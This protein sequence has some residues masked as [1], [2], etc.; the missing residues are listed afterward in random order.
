M[1]IYRIK[2]LYG[3]QLCILFLLWLLLHHRSFFK[4][5]F[6]L[7]FNIIFFNKLQDI[8]C[9]VPKCLLGVNFYGV[10]TSYS[11]YFMFLLFGFCVV[12]FYIYIYLFM[13][14]DTFLYVLFVLETSSKAYR[15]NNYV[16]DSQEFELHDNHKQH[17]TT[18][19]FSSMKTSTQTERKNNENKKIV[20]L[21]K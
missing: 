21:V 10:L 15:R 3:L 7:L 6:L 17:S 5:S 4:V 18:N 20:L 11:K 9:S 14:Y 8:Y 16:L 19:N 13:L 12:F 1:L 2:L